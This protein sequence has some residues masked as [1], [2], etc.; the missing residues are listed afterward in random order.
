MEK[1]EASDR[2]NSLQKEHRVTIIANELSMRIRWLEEEK[3]FYIKQ[4]QENLKR[5]N[6]RIKGAEKWLKELTD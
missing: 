3:K 1:K 5:I 4:H 2:F 6:E